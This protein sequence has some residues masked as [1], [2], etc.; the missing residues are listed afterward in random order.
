MENFE[1][2]IIIETLVIILILV[3][4]PIL[5]K[6]IIKKFS[7]NRKHFSSDDKRLEEIYKNM[8]K[9]VDIEELESLIEK[10]IQHESNFRIKDDDKRFEEMYNNMLKNINIEELEEL[11]KKAIQ[12]EKEFN[13]IKAYKDKTGFWIAFLIMM[14]LGL[15]SIGIAVVGNPMLGGM[16]TY[17]IIILVPIIYNNIVKK[18]NKKP[19]INDIT[20]YKDKYKEKIAPE[21]LKQFEGIPREIYDMAEFEMYDT[22]ES[23]DMMDIMLKNDCRAKMA[24]VL[25]TYI[26]EGRKGRIYH[27]ILFAGIFALIETPK[28]FKEELYVKQDEE[29]TVR[30]ITPKCEKIQLDSPEFEQY[31][32]IYGTNKIVA[33]QLLTADIMQMLIDFRKDTGIE[34]DFAIKNNRIFLRFEGGGLF[35]I[36]NLEK[37]LW[38]KDIMYRDYKILNF[39][40]ALTYKITKL[41]EETE[42]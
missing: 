16:L 41:I 35:E 33:M 27:K 42:Y 25:T 1:I 28:K 26:S 34:F 18:R 29:L 21:F 11:R 30:S 6:F 12:Y 3:V 36:P 2:A 31:F 20:I 10:T 23:E 14:T 5:N 8:L 39:T 38:D 13:T 32:D 9:N 24:E 7:N 37:T 4:W 19:S 17:A 15:F 40:F 22:Y